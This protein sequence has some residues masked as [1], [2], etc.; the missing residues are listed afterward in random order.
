MKTI[1]FTLVIMLSAC[2]QKPAQTGLPYFDTPDFK[3]IWIDKTTAGFQTL[4]TIP[5]FSFTDQDG[6][7]ITDKTV[8]H[9]IYVVNFFFTK[10]GSICPKMTDNMNKVAHA[11]INDQRVLMLSHSVTPALDNPSILKSYAK[12]KNIVNPNW[13]L[14]TGNKQQIYEIARKGYFAED[15]VGYNKDFSQFLHTENFVLVDGHRHIRGVYN[16]TIDFEIENLVRHIK[17]L[18][19]EVD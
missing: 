2:H 5:G 7:S 12:Q 19:Q 6:K 13:H 18:E 14:L 3:P 9:K 10:C 1:L 17:M 11:F 15:A 8:A 4:H 16:G